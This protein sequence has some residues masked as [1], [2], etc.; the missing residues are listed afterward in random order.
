MELRIDKAT[1]SKKH[2][3]N[4]KFSTELLSVFSEKHKEIRK[5]TVPH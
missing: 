4:K 5:T 2:K 3:L 1:Y